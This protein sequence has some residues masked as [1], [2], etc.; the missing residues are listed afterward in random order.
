[1][2]GDIK[3]IPIWLTDVWVQSGEY[4]VNPL[5]I[6]TKRIDT[7]LQMKRV[8]MKMLRFMLVLRA[9]ILYLTGFI[10]KISF[11]AKN[12]VLFI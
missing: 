3:E 8:L 1:M 9:I 2:K 4:F 6:K 12:W 7:L 5:G 11:L 10:T